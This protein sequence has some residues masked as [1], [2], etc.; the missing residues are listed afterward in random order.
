MQLYMFLELKAPPTEIG[1]FHRSNSFVFG[2]FCVEKTSWLFFA[3]IKKLV[4]NIPSI[5]NLICNATL[6]IYFP[7]V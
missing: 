2:L 7:I 3:L 5:K 4:F 6:S 1:S